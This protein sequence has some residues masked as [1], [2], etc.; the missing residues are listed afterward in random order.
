MYSARVGG[1][2]VS[3]KTDLNDMDTVFVVDAAA[4]GLMPTGSRAQQIVTVMS[5]GS[6]HHDP[7]GRRLDTCQAGCGA[8]RFAGFRGQP[9]PCSRPPRWAGLALAVPS[10]ARTG[11]GTAPSS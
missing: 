5:Q 10:K 4:V 11:S 7:V 3:S 9:R 1:S 6:T 8:H 2:V